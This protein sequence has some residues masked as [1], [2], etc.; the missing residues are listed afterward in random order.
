MKLGGN[1]ENKNYYVVNNTEWA[2]SRNTWKLTPIFLM[3]QWMNKLNHKGPLELTSIRVGGLFKPAPKKKHL[4][5]LL[6]QFF[7]ITLIRGQK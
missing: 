5:A 6:A 2:R 1:F 4:E 7:H 3:N